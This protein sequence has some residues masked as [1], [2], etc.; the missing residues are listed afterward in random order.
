VR[1]L[2]LA[3]LTAVVLGPRPPAARPLIAD[4]ICVG[5]GPLVVMGQQVVPY[6]QVCAPGQ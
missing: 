6:E 4:P 1:F 2:A 5:A 3:V